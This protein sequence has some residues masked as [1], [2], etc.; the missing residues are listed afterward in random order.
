MPI[1]QYRCLFNLKML[2]FRSIAKLIK[3][4]DKNEEGEENPNRTGVYRTYGS[5]IG[6]NQRHS[7]KEKT[8][9]HTE[10]QDCLY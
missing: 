6:M 5:R 7:K 2:S 3:V 1:H 10:A 4:M 8:N 9:D